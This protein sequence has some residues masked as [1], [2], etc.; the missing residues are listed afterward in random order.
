MALP[1]ESVLDTSNR[2][3]AWSMTFPRAL[4]VV[5]VKSVVFFMSTMFSRNCRSSF[6]TPATRSQELLAAMEGCQVR[7]YSGRGF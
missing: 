5:E 4:L 7:A 2:Q 6:R 1:R 3:F